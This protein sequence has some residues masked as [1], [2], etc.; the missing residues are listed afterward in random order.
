MNNK[1]NFNFGY[2]EEN[3]EIKKVL[4]ND[5]R[6]CKDYVDNALSEL[7]NAKYKN[8]K[9]YFDNAIIEVSVTKVKN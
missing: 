7:I 9:L 5:L 1:R 8:G 6:E 2:G 3:T 4:L